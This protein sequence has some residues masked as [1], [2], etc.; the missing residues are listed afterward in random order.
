MKRLVLLLTVLVAGIANAQSG[1]TNMIGPEGGWSAT[2][3]ATV[4]NEKLYTVEN[5]GGIYETDLT[6]TEKKPI[7][8]ASFGNSRFIFSANSSLYVIDFNGTIF[9]VDPATAKKEKVGIEGAWSDITVIA[10]CKD[11]LFTIDKKGTLKSTNLITNATR[12]LGSSYINVVSLFA[13]TDKVYLLEGS[14]KV[15]EMNPLNASQKPVSGV[16]TWASI[17]AGCGYKGGVYMIDKIGVLAS[18][19][20][21][22]GTKTKMGKA[23]FRQATFLFGANGMLYFIENTGNLYEIKL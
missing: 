17:I 9:K 5:N 22:A 14:G 16:G 2:V 10:V 8:P 13:T 15:N 11:L 3:Y 12:E 21:G 19:D 4:L 1:A 20:T 6:T 18:M 23:E 7:G